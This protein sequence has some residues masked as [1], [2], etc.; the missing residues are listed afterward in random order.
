MCQN[1]NKIG[2]KLQLFNIRNR[3]KINYYRNNITIK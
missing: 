2:L 1:V 3:N